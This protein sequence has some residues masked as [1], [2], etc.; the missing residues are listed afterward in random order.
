MK[1]NKAD[2]SAEL[3]LWLDKHRHTHPQEIDLGLHRVRAVADNMQLLNPEQTVVTVAGTNGKGSTVALLESMLRAAGYK[4]ASYTSP[5]M[6][7]YNERIKI[8]NRCLSD[9]ELCRSF[10]MIEA[11]RGDISLS[12]F[13]F[14]TL[15]ALQCFKSAKPDIILLETGLGGRLDAV[16]IID[17]DLAIITSIG[18]D[19]V[20]WLGDNRNSIGYE[21]AGI[22]RPGVPCI[23]GDIAPPESIKALN[24]DR[25]LY[26]INEDFSYRRERDS[27][28]F[29]HRD[30]RLD[31]LPLPALFGD[32]QLQNASCVVMALRCLAANF[33]VSYDDIVAG[34]TTAYLP[35][36][37]QIKSQN[38]EGGS[39]VSIFDISHNP[40][41]VEVMVENLKSLTNGRELHAVFAI[42]ATKDADSI[43]KIVAPMVDHWHLSEPDSAHALPV[44][45]LKSIVE[46]YTNASNSIQCFN[47]V[48]EAYDD[49]MCNMKNGDRL[50]AFGSTMT[51]AEA[52]KS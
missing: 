23:C 31:D 6:H 39:I 20:E 19:H 7:R 21:K 13:E 45:Q 17:A 27:W 2:Y 15:A 36:R 18:I 22:T 42:L 4:T 46:R 43:T 40:Q 3:Q 48:S 52:L 41:G 37:F 38:I 25:P 51:V 11:H 8:N 24:K 49:A 35:G 44:E 33:Q 14:S 12:F 50:L 30:F 1:S 9:G 10:E 32:I 26:L 5:H 28:Y 34:L 29:E 47:S 16:N